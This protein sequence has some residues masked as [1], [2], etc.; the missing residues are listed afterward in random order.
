MCP[1]VFMWARHFEVT[2]LYLIIKFVCLGWWSGSTASNCYFSHC[3]EAWVWQFHI[4]DIVFSRLSTLNFWCILFCFRLQI[5]R[6]GTSL[7][8]RFQRAGYPVIMLK[9]QYRMHPEVRSDLY[10]RSSKRWIV[11]LIILGSTFYPIKK[12]NNRVAPL[13]SRVQN[14]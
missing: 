12:E 13:Y 10:N 7:F 14:Y 11:K 5:W 4:M 3:R 8:K 2:M 6:Y 9:T 1:H